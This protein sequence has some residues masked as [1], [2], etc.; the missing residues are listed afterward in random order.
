M[1]SEK[2]GRWK[3]KK[4]KKKTIQDPSTLRRVPIGKYIDI[5]S[6]LRNMGLKIHRSRTNPTFEAM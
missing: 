3:K 5:G 6:I 1:S 2:W 4:E